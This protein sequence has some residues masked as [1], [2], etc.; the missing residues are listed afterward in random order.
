MLLLPS[1][2]HSQNPPKLLQNNGFSQFAH[3]IPLYEIIRFWYD[4]LNVPSY[5]LQCLKREDFRISESSSDEESLIVHKKEYS[6]RVKRY[7]ERIIDF[8]NM[9][10]H[11]FEHFCAEVLT[12]NGYE[13]VT[14]TQGSGDQGIDYHCL[15]G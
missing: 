1:I 8:D 11:V 12:L 9:E 14:V 15:Q 4:S 13:N 5:F 6:F 2:G 7:S 3:L 10:G